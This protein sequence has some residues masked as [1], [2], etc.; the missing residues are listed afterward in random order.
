M[1]LS[2]DFSIVMCFILLLVSIF[3]RLQLIQNTAARLLTRTKISDHI[4]PILAQLY[5][6][7]VRFWNCFKIL[8]LILK[9]LNG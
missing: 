9:A 7:A 4:T 6:L 3:Q 8:L 2:P 5:W 1:L